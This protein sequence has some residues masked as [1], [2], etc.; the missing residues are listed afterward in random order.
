MI[1][2]LVFGIIIILVGLGLFLQESGYIHSFW[3]I[4]WPL[5][6]VIFGVLVLAGALYGRRRY[7]ETRR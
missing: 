6:I 7:N 1:A 5:I 4:F 2:G 3:S